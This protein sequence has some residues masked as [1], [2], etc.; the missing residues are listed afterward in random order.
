MNYEKNETNIEFKDEVVIFE[1][2]MRF[3]DYNIKIHKGVKIGR[4]TKIME[5]VVIRENVVIGENC[6]IGNNSLIRK[7]VLL[8]DKVK[9]GFA[10]VIE[11]NAKIGT[12]T[13]IHGLCVISEFSVIGKGVF[14]APF[15]NNPADKDCN[16][17]EGEY[18][19]NPASIGDNV[20]IGSGVKLKPG[21]HI[22]DDAFIWMGSLVTKD[23]PNG[24]V[25]VGSPA[26][27]REPKTDSNGNQTLEKPKLETRPMLRD[28]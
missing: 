9:V 10:T 19:P 6:I 27:K 3:Q 16:K 1:N 18:K 17:F 22:G 11:P 25:W 20:R 23:V 7:N 4:G 5:N 21:I 2:T 28:Y 24:E 13:S 26:S 8:E 12:G 15:L 14:I